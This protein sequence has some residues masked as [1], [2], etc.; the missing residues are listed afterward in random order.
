[1]SKTLDNIQLE[2]VVKWNQN[3]YFR[4]M[5]TA[6]MHSHENELLGGFYTLDMKR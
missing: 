4:L 1:M 6:I 2:I 5:F 3:N